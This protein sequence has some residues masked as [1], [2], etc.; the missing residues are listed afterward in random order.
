MTR[1]TDL[2]ATA[3]GGK[4]TEATTDPRIT[5]VRT[6]TRPGSVLRARLI[7]AAI[8]PYP[9]WVRSHPR[10]AAARA[11][12]KGLLRELGATIAG[13]RPDT[14]TVILGKSGDAASKEIEEKRGA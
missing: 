3:T 7:L 12:Y 2:L 1:S 8:T 14:I 6:F 9:V 10:S 4:M 11:G 5:G 13:Y